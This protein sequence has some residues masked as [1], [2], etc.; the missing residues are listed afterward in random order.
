[1]VVDLSRS[2]RKPNLSSPPP[3]SAVNNISFNSP[4]SDV[5]NLSNIWH[6]VPPQQ[7]FG[8]IA[9][10][11]ESGIINLPHISSN[12]SVRIKN[13]SSSHGHKRTPAQKSYDSSC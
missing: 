9:M 7:S 13:P 6:I 4:R 11:T 12:T 10:G 1:M 8:I 2:I 5:M 3:V